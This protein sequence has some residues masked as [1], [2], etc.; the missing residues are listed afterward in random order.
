[1][2]N[3]TWFITGTSRGFGREWTEAALARGDRVAA[4]ARDASTL[5]DL[6]AQHGDGLL[7]RALDVTDREQAFAAVREAHE[8]YGS[9]ACASAR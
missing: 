8:H 7:A 3:K 4:T 1:M 2:P 9:T 5:D 6:K